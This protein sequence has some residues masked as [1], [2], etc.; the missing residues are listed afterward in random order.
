MPE[1]FERIAGVNDNLYIESKSS[2]GFITVYSENLGN[3]SAANER[4]SDFIPVSKNEKYVFQGWVTV[5]E[6]GY[7][8]HRYHYYDADKHKV[9]GPYYFE[10]NTP[11]TGE[12]HYAEHI[13]VPNDDDIAYIRISARL[14]SDGKLK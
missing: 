7:P 10:S 1:R 9:G 12:Q 14:Y 8:W 13:T 2:A 5:P 4:T 6:N 11:L 3:P